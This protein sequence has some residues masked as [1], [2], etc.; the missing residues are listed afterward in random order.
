MFSPKLC[1]TT[2]DNKDNTVI[3]MKH[4]KM[5]QKHHHNY[6]GYK[7]QNPKVLG[8]SVLNKVLTQLHIIVTENIHTSRRQDFFSGAQETQRALKQS[9]ILI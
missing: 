2:G 5:L 7:S 1:M 4:K 6:Q 3:D 8:K 9:P